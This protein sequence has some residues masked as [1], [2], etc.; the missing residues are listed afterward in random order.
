MTYI[1][2][3]KSSNET[4]KK[5]TVS[6]Y[7]QSKHIGTLEIKEVKQLYYYKSPRYIFSPQ[8]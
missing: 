6:R 4:E 8:R 7:L 2:I 5:D 1:F 3:P